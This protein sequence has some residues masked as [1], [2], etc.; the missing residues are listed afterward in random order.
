ME[1]T[2]KCQG[3]Q[4]GGEKD[5]IKKKSKEISQRTFMRSPRTQ[6]RV[7]EAQGGKMETGW[8]NGRHL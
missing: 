7:C 5:W 2:D 3:K 6:T 4:V 1:E 8:G